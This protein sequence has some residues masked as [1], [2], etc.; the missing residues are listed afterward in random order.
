MDGYIYILYVYIYMHTCIHAY[1]HTCIHA[2]VCTYMHTYVYVYVYVY[3][4]IIFCI[5]IHTHT[6]YTHMYVC[7]YMYVYIYILGG[8]GGGGLRYVYA[9]GTMAQTFLEEP[10]ARPIFSWTTLRSAALRLRYEIWL[11]TKISKFR[12]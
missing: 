2:Y 8:E 10:G 1:M 3:I 6:K 12:L 5:Y 7:I 9:A 11:G 4:Y